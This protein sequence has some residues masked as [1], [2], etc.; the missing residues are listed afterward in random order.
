MAKTSIWYRPQGGKAERIE[1]CEEH[2]ALYLAAEYR[3]AF[4]CG[5]YQHRY[6]KDKVWIGRKKDEPVSDS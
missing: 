3:I 5:F 6:G 2:E 4:A 1:I